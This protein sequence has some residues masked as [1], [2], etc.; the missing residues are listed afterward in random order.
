MNILLDYFAGYS[1]FYIS[2]G[3]RGRVSALLIDNRIPYTVRNMKDGT[4]RLK[5][6]LRKYETAF[7]LLRENQIKFA[8]SL[9]KG[10]PAFLSKLI[11]RP[12]FV[13]GL[14]LFFAVSWFSSRIVWDIRVS[15]NCSFTKEEIETVLLSENFA[16]GTFFEMIDFDRLNSS[17]MANNPDIAWISV[18]M[19]GNVAEVDVRKAEHG[20]TPERADGVYAN[21]V[22]GEEAQIVLIHTDEGTTV[23]ADGDIVKKGDLLISGIVPLRNEGVRFVYASGEISADVNR[24]ISVRVDNT[25]KEKVYTGKKT[26]DK[27]VIFFKKKIN[28]FSNGGIEYTSYDKIDKKER[29]NLFGMIPLPFWVEKTEYRE[30]TEHETEL[31]PEQAMVAAKKK[32]REMSDEV[33][34]DAELISKKIIVLPEKDGIT[35]R[36]DM[37]CRT[38][39]GKTVEFTVS[40]NK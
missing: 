2:D 34:D 4:F 37:V 40:D 21:I 29:F 11:I 38:D 8:V 15:D 13:V 30:Y 35:L 5:I 1:F 7:S 28:L 3:F 23:A 26:D 33:L 12:G 31:T 36:C 10:L 6:R 32:L 22:A 24:S 14:I 39:I 9:K 18:N 17:I 19:R 27:S 16:Y 20:V 25:V